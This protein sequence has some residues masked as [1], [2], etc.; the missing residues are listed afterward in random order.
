MKKARLQE[1]R[2][3]EIEEQMPRIK[4]RTKNVFT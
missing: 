3:K 2:E 4:E 1:E